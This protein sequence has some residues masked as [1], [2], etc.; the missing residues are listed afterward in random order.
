MNRSKENVKV[1]H[2]QILRHTYVVLTFPLFS[3]TTN[4]NKGMQVFYIFLLPQTEETNLKD[5]FNVINTTEGNITIIITAY[6][7]CYDLY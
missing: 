7:F 5:F 1:E 4:N 6:C 3:R 2:E